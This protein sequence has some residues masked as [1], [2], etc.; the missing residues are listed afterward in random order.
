MVPQERRFRA[1]E[2]GE[3]GE[4]ACMPTLLS[5]FHLCPH[6]SRLPNPPASK[7]YLC[8]SFSSGIAQVSSGDHILTLS[9]VQKK[10]PLRVTA[11]F[12]HTG[13]WGCTRRSCGGY[14]TLVEI[15]D[16]LL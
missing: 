7:G 13:Q 3:R 2:Q 11:C 16:I 4:C 9:F 5:R 12:A 6:V 10:R 8:R 15:N 1:P 14:G